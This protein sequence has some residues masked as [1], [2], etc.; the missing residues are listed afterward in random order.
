M[1][2]SRRSRSGTRRSPARNRFVSCPTR[3]TSRTSR[4]PSSCS[5]SRAARRSSHLSPSRWPRLES[6]PRWLAARSL[7][8]AATR[9]RSV[10]SSGMTPARFSRARNASRRYATGA[11]GS[12][13]A[14]RLGKVAGAPRH[15]ALSSR[16]K[17]PGLT[18]ASTTA[19]PSS[20][21]LRSSP[22]GS[23]G[24]SGPNGASTLSIG[25]PSGLRG[26]SFVI[27]TIDMKPIPPWFMPS[28]PMSPWL[29]P[30]WGACSISPWP[31]CCSPPSGCPACRANRLSGLPIVAPCESSGYIRV[32]LALPPLG[33]ASISWCM[34]VCPAVRS[35]WAG[36]ECR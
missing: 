24:K 3:A 1:P 7:S 8:S 16:P 30:A 18:T 27:S 2:L 13:R 28:C 22:P 4:V 35:V 23:P 19:S 5:C 21:S 26:R 9:A 34:S 14:S 10:R 15:A 6:Q 17:V 31:S 36:S 33:S 25:R 20:V 11:S 12:S 32:S 29:I